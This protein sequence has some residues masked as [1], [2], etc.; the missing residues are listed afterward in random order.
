M[1]TAGA[2]A[3]AGSMSTAGTS[4]TMSTA[5]SMSAGGEGGAAGSAGMGAAGT[6]APASDRPPATSLS[7]PIKT[8]KVTEAPTFNITRP[9]KLDEGGPFPV[10][11]WANG[12]CFRSD[13][14]WQPLFE[15]WAK[16][17][18]VVLH[19]TGTGG[20]DD[21]ASMLQTTTKAEHKALIDWVDTQNKSGPF[22][23]KLDIERV[24]VA[25]NS[26]GG[27]T[28]LQVAAEEERLAAVFVL[29]GSSAVGSTDTA[30]MKKVKVP[31]GFI[32]GGSEDIAAPNAAG[33]YE[34]LNDG[35][36]A[37]IVNRKTGDH[38]TVSTDPMV[39]PE[40][41]EIALNWMDLAVNGTKAALE[42]LNSANHCGVCT[43]GDWM[44]KSKNL[45]KLQK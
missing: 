25:G 33:D 17:G 4:A 43:P 10:V 15:R 28:A 31:V 13:F 3:T 40:V 39:A 2:T 37:M 21:I 8:E 7:L 24:V 12:G 1:S 29:S 23:G 41:A 45:E 22:A 6:G 26:C 14:T 18:F 32:V 9:E 44:I 20:M 36:P 30:V 16:G 34:A 42:A 35:V 19:L 11:V 5:G 27:V 38:V